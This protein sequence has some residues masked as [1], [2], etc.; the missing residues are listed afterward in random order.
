MKQVEAMYSSLPPVTVLTSKTAA[1][2]LGRAFGLQHDFRNDT[3]IMSFGRNP[4]KLSECAAEWLEAHRYFNIDQ[5]QTHFDNPT[6]IQM[7]TP[8]ASPPYANR[9]PL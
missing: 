2:E 9:S 6:T 7:L 5:S 3:Y 1:H 4:N 8:F